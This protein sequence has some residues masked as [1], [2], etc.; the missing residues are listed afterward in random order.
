MD[1]GVGG[2]LEGSYTAYVSSASMQTKM[3]SGAFRVCHVLDVP[4]P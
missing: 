1:Q 3:L 2:V 4:K